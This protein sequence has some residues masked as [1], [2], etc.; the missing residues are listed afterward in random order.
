[1]SRMKT[2]LQ[3]K[4]EPQ[5]PKSTPSDRPAAGATRQKAKSSG[6]RKGQQRPKHPSKK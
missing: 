3:K 6:Q 1:M 5:D 4:D 2:S